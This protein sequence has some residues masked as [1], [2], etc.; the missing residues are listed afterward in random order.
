M[1]TGTHQDKAGGMTLEGQPEP[2]S[3]GGDGSL[4]GVAYPLGFLTV[5]YAFNYFDRQ[6]LGLLLPQIKADLQLSDTQ[7][8][9]ISG[10]AFALCYAVAG[11][12]LASLADRIGR[13]GII[14]MGFLFWSLAT[15]LTGLVGS[16]WALAVT[17]FLTGAGEAAGIAPS[18]AMV[19]DM[20]SE[21]RRPLALGIL[22]S[23]NA[24][25]TIVLFPMAGWFAAAHGWRATFWAAGALGLVLALLFLLTVEERRV[26][27]RSKMA[28]KAVGMRDLMAS[29]AFRLLIVG[30]SLMGIS[31]YATL[32]WSPTYLARTHGLSVAHLA[33]V[34][35]P[36]RGA[37]SLCGALIGG[38]LASHL[39]QSDRRWL[40]WLSGLACV[41]VVPFEVL[42]LFAPDLGG[43][44]TGLALTGLLSA[45][46]VTPCFAACAL[47]GGAVQRATATAI[48]L[49][50][51]NLVGQ[52]VG[53]LLVGAGSDFLAPA[54]GV[55]AFRTSM[56]LTSSVPL[57]AGIVF[58]VAGYALPA[59]SH[60]ATTPTGRFPIQKG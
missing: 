30:G 17:R 7:L 8:G 14:G 4:A 46:H 5:V 15:A 45:L 16:G 58:A 56:L 49:F 9:L 43:A 41:A 26:A 47:L 34:V 44:L 6:L 51:V 28:E 59:P 10:A 37:T 12:P 3:K 1:E 27:P 38:V 53:P 22:S 42:F 55:N 29:P 33:G 21:R 60:S 52:I 13:K 23:G 31:L 25:G 57:A 40:F 11:I 48:F 50:F 24:L 32:V 54:L 18:S 2:Q 19:A 36:I 20:V 35:G 39:G